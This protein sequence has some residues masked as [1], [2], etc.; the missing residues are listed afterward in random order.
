MVLQDCKESTNPDEKQVLIARF[1]SV[2]TAWGGKLHWQNT[3]QQHKV[4][5]VLPIITDREGLGTVYV[6][7]WTENYCQKPCG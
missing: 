5:D 1:D 3:P 2:S 7:Q 4:E 6:T